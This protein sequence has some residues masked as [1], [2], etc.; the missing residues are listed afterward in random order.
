MLQ[1]PPASCPLAFGAPSIRQRPWPPARQRVASRVR[2][3]RRSAI[4]PPA[5]TQH[6]RQQRTQRR[7]WQGVG[8]S[9]FQGQHHHCLASSGPWRTR[10]CPGWRA[11]QCAADSSC[12]IK[13]HCC[14]AATAGRWRQCNATGQHIRISPYC[15]HWHK[16]ERG[17]VAIMQCR[18]C[19]SERLKVTRQ[20]KQLKRASV[21]QVEHGTNC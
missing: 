20:T 10:Q 16:Q 11:Q 2:K 7:A 3:G 5:G 4:L 17:P 8:G 13:R 14:A 12:F 19:R 15:D 9:L 21:H 1:G 18:C 6:G